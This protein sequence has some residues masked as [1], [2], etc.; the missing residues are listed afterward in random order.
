MLM[1]EIK[2]PA[3]RGNNTVVRRMANKYRLWAAIKN[4]GALATMSEVMAATG[5]S[6]S[7]I[8]G[9]CKQ[10]GWRVEPDEAPPVELDDLMAGRD[11]GDRV[12]TL[13][14]RRSNGLRYRARLSS[15]R[16][17]PRSLRDIDDEEF[18]LD[19]DGRLN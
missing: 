18:G 17:A 11:P 7:T 6:E 3:R 8:W 10:T 13:A 16:G 12:V 14:S 4:L 1:Q 9:L 2:V 15:L 5:L 19:D